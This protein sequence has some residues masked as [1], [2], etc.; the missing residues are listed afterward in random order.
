MQNILSLYITRTHL[1]LLVVNRGAEGPHVLE[2]ASFPLEEDISASV[3]LFLT[4]LREREIEYQRCIL[5]LSDEYFF[6]RY[7]LLPF[8]RREQILQTLPM[9][10]RSRLPLK[11]DDIVCRFMFLQRSKGHSRIMAVA[12]SHEEISKILSILEENNISPHVITVDALVVANYLKGLYGEDFLLVTPSPSGVKVVFP[13]GEG[14]VY[15]RLPHSPKN[16]PLLLDLGRVD[17]FFSHLLP[18]VVLPTKVIVAGKEGKIDNK[19]LE[20]LDVI[21]LEENCGEKMEDLVPLVA[22]SLDGRGLPDFAETRE[23]NPFTSFFEENFRTIVVSILTVCL[24]F[25]MQFLTSTYFLKKQDLEI[26]QEIERIFRKNFPDIN[27]PLQPIQYPSIF[28]QKI[29]E[30]QSHLR[31]SHSG[32]NVHVLDVLEKISRVIPKDIDVTIMRMYY[33]GGSLH[34]AGI[35]HSFEDVGKIRQML[36]DSRYFKKVQLK[37]A[38]WNSEKSKVEFSLDITL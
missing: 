18:D 17:G 26:R 20:E 15:A 31:V 6:F 14:L 13:W 16:T 8:S 36:V 5:V 9:E 33:A 7:L 2:R 10:M 4:Q 21:S 11:G 23:M 24:L 38:A 22:S 37:R 29:E 32:G 27:S 1:H 35:A 3:S 19:G 25:T 34:L 30:M 28:R 12:I